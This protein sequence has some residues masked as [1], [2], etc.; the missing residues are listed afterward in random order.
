VHS[1]KSASLF[2]RG[3]SAVRSNDDSPPAARLLRALTGFDHATL[4]QLLRARVAL[5]PDSLFLIAGSARW[6][7]AAAWTEI[8][9]FATFLRDSG[10]MPGERVASYLTN[11]PESLWSWFGTLV[12]GA[13]YVPLNRN[14]RGRLLC[15]LTQRSRA[16]VLVTEM[17]GLPEL[18]A[19]RVPLDSH[20][21]LVADAACDDLAGTAKPFPRAGASL[22]I[23]VHASPA[24][25]AMLVFTSGTTGRS[26]AVRLPHNMYCRGG[27]ALAQALDLRGDDVFHLWLPLFH[28]A[29]QLH[30]TVSTI[31]AGG[32]IALFPAFSR[33]RF[34]QEVA[35]SGA[36]IFAGLPNVLQLLL[37]A[38]PQ[39][40][41]ARHSLRLGIAA[42]APAELA[43]EFSH[44]F[45]VRLSDTYGMTEVEPLTL[46]T[47]A[48]PPGSCGVAGRDFEIGIV[49]AEDRAVSSG[50]RG[51][52][53]A[54]PRVPG[55]MMQGYEDDDVAT[56]AACSNLWFH[57]G[58]L[59]Y[60]DADGFIYL[61][62][63]EKEM[64]RRG[65]ENISAF[66]LESLIA[67]HP[68]IAEVAVV[69]VPSP[70][71]DEEVKAVVVARAG[72]TVDARQ[73]HRFCQERM[74]RF[75]VPRFIDV[76]ERLPY[77]ELGK[78]RR[79]ELAGTTAG[80]WDAQAAH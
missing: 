45:A 55:V 62:G 14:H 48:T 44:R 22:D 47:R 29:G 27:D 60:R 76:R 78:V 41:D 73:I 1:P 32:A 28:I 53:V 9:R 59:G 42:G 74:A 10:V 61:L 77:S 65:G 4:P 30:A 67:E 36:T 58:D 66:E 68:A 24:E 49:D 71:G 13:V 63:R 16:R 69:S 38:P 46:P 21:V 11:R 52:I 43:R 19:T 18:L 35:E 31:I 75:M 79:D 51:R 37:S 33:S 80:S 12:A 20:R 7:Y 72:M 56:L 70:R 8:L 17:S 26:K 25:V 57:T 6:T 3:A 40:G 50:I 54:R 34:W 2:S 5:T 39:P 64:I 15:E 23:E